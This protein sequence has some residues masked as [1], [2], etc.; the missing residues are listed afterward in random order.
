MI[1]NVWHNKYSKEEICM[2]YLC[3]Q[4]ICL[5]YKGELPNNI[6]EKYMWEFFSIHSKFIK[7]VK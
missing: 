1:K 5:Q 7:E 4:Y 2:L 6:L 3:L